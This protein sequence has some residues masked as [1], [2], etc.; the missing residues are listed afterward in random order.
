MKFITYSSLGQVFQAV[1]AGIVW[2]NGMYHTKSHMVCVHNQ[3]CGVV[4][5]T[6]SHG[7]AT[8]SLRNFAQNILLL[9]FDS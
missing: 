3:G 8:H 1:C 9:V 2:P 6:S 5:H 7:A 4:T